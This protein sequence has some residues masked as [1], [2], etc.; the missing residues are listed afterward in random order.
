[1]K[2]FANVMALLAAMVMALAL[3]G[4][5]DGNGNGNGNGG[6]VVLATEWEATQT[7]KKGTLYPF[8]ETDTDIVGGP[9]KLAFYDNGTYV[10]SGP[11]EVEHEGDYKGT[12]TGNT[13]TP[14]DWITLTGDIF[15]AGGSGAVSDDGNSLN[16]RYYVGHSGDFSFE[17]YYLFKKSE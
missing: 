1:M 11:S 16:L 2:R 3:A 6:K 13:A 15:V 4:C 12:Y 5:S 10:W 17:Y 7:R 14:G 8:R 9:I